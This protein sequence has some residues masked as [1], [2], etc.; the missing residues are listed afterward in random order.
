MDELELSITPKAVHLANKPKIS[1]R[2]NTYSEVDL[3]GGFVSITVKEKRDDAQVALY[4]FQVPDNVTEINPFTLGLCEAVVA[5]RFA[6]ETL[7]NIV[8][9]TSNPVPQELDEL[10]SEYG[11]ATVKFI[12]DVYKTDSLEYARG[13]TLLLSGGV[14]STGILFKHLKGNCNAVSLSH[15]QPSFHIGIWPEKKAASTVVDMAERAFG[16]R[17]EHRILRARFDC[18]PPRE[19]AK[20]YRNFLSILQASVVFPNTRIWIGTNLHDELHDCDPVFINK[21]MDVTGI[22]IKVPWE[23]VGRREIMK[24]MI[25][26][27]MNKYPYLYASTSSCQAGRFLGGKFFLCGSCHSCLLRLPAAEFSAD[28]RFQNFNSHMKL[29]PQSLVGKFTTMKYFRGRPSTNIMKS[30][31]GDFQSEKT[32]RDFIP[33]LQMIKNYWDFEMDTFLTDMQLGMISEEGDI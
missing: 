16:K 28:P 12:G 8:H 2:L 14:D 15:G 5:A 23:A 30:F 1:K 3:A 17:I 20:A 6:T 24:N 10:L 4:K 11:L 27:S 31:F 29:I 21:F 25:E 9:N 18:E 7:I 33:C 32:F 19:W 26:M 22:Q 13:N